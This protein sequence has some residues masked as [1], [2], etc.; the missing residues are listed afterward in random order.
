M[1][2]HHLIALLINFQLSTEIA[3]LIGFKPHFCYKFIFIYFLM[4]SNITYIIFMYTWKTNFSLSL[5]SIPFNVINVVLHALYFMLIKSIVF[6]F[7]SYVGFA[8]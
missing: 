6:V 8:I 7:S 5:V 1:P 4:L 3:M 2:R